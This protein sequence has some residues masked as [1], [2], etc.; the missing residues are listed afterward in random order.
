MKIIIDRAAFE[1][2]IKPG[3]VFILNEEPDGEGEDCRP[4]EELYWIRNA[5]EIIGAIEM[6]FGIYLAE[7]YEF[8]KLNGVRKVGE[9]CYKL[10]LVCYDREEE[11]E[12]PYTLFLH[13]INSF[14]EML[15]KA[16]EMFGVE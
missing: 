5:D 15:V 13:R 6:E 3:D 12:E 16:K 9:S 2:V 7:D 14:G 8:R 4:I 10:E 1:G 11:K